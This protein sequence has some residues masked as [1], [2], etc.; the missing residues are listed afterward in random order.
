[1]L[2]NVGPTSLGEIPAASID[3]LAAIGEWLKI[4]KESIYGTTASPFPYLSWGRCTRKGQKLFLHVFDY[5]ANG[6]LA[7]PLSNKISKAYL[8]SK[9]KKKLAVT[10]GNRRSVITLPAQAPDSIN[11]VVVVE[12]AGEPLVLPSPVAGKQIVASSQKADNLSP[13]N[14]LDGARQTRW[15]AA[16]GERSATLDIDL[17][18]PFTISTIIADEPWHLWE[19]KKQKL[20]LQYKSGNEWK[21]VNE[22]T[23]NG[24]GYVKNFTAVTAQHFRLIVERTDGEP[25]L[26]EW[27]LYGPE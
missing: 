27:Q 23:S 17:A 25:V 9:P 4:N 13:K 6:K 16:K 15:E 14:L 7:V 12:F 24:T 5:P 19:N 22:G 20:T 10:T 21:T 18:K 1:M 26:L 2:L 3:R 8:L 11:T